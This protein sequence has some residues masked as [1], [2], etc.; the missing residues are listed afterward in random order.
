[1]VGDRRNRLLNGLTASGVFVFGAAVLWVLALIS[2]WSSNCPH[3]R[4]EL[5]GLDKGISAWPPGA[6]CIDRAHDLYYY[7][8]EPW[9][10]PVIF[11]LL[12]CATVVLVASVVAA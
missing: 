12:V 4:L 10:K 2:S 11:A 7:E 5:T 1:M 6:Q 9:V 8:A 3:R